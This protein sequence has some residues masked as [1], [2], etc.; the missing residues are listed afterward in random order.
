MKLSW[1][2]GAAT[3]TNN[4]LVSN[5]GKIGES[6]CYEWGNFTEGNVGFGTFKNL[7]LIE[8]GLDSSEDN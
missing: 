5:K 6:G 7:L 4:P 2:D 8:A 3:R 1:N